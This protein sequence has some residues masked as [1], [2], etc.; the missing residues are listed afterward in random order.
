MNAHIGEAI[1]EIAKDA[2]AIVPCEVCGGCY[3]RNEDPDADAMA[4]AMAT[5]AWKEGRLR[6]L[7]RAEAV[8]AMASCLQSAN[9]RCPSCP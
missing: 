8:S 3:V 4:Y 6:G 2:G 1:R 5:N 9:D 7:T